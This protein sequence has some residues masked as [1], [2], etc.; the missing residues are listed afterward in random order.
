METVDLI[1]QSPSLSTE[2]RRISL[3][4]WTQKKVGDLLKNPD[5]LRSLLGLDEMNF[6]YFARLLEKKN[7]SMSGPPLRLFDG[8]EQSPGSVAY[9]TANAPS[10]ILSHLPLVSLKDLQKPTYK[11]TSQGVALW[12]KKMHAG[13]GTTV[14]R[15]SH[16]AKYTDRSQAD[17]GAK[18]TDLFIPL[19]PSKKGGPPPRVSLAEA[20]LLQGILEANRKDYAAVL[21]HDIVSLATEPHFVELWKHPQLFENHWT[22]AEYVRRAD[23]LGRT[24]GVKQAMLPTLT[25][26]G[27]LSFH[28]LAPGGHALFAFEAIYA[29]LSEDLLPHATGKHLVSFL[30]NGEDL[31]ASPSPEMVGWMV[32]EKIAVA[33]VVTEKTRNDRKGGQIALVE[34]PQKGT[35]VTIIETAQAKTANQ[36]DLFERTGLDSHSL[37]PAYFNTNMALLHYDV[38]KPCIQELVARVGKEAFLQRIAPDLIENWKEQVDPDGVKRRYLQL[39]GAMG[40]TLLNLDR[41]YREHFQKPLVHFIG[42]GKEE[43]DAYFA[44]VKTAFDFYLQFYSDRFHLN[45]MTLKPVNR[46]PGQL[47]EIQLGGN[48][49]T[50]KFWEDVENVLAAFEGASVMQLD[51]LKVQGTV[52]FQGLVLEGKVEVEN[53]GGRVELGPLLKKKSLKNTRIEITKEGEWKETAL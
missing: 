18:G 2:K 15:A 49:E 5:E 4:D 29:A 9:L 35:Y 19:S 12:R 45:A 47:P 52:S 43:R 16:L 13:L 48:K 41:L 21:F 42:V 34:D 31:A 17:L 14:L 33:M 7:S 27:K 38:L 44:P 37:H 50:P 28:R 39:E 24:R 53:A 10:S 36:L 11:K 8:M 40:S 32:E 1:Q 6:L 3:G 22:Y 26:G 20:L 46:R 51:S 30:A 25:E 23:R